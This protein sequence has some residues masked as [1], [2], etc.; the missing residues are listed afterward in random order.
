MEDIMKYRHKIIVVVFCIALLSLF[1]GCQTPG[2]RSAGEVVD[3][4]GITAQ[5]K[6]KIFQDSSLSGFAISVS[7]FEGQVQLVG[8]VN[9]AQD[10]RR[11][12]DIALSVRGVKKVNNLL[13]IK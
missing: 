3:D 4:A 9:S 8:A 11:A 2:G 6:T 13:K 7:T 12:T 10:K 5:V 1:L